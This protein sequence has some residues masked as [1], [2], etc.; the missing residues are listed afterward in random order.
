MKVVN[1]SEYRKVTTWIDTKRGHTVIRFVF[2]WGTQIEEKTEFNTALIVSDEN[3]KWELAHEVYI[4]VFYE[5]RATLPYPREG[6]EITKFDV[7]NYNF[8]K[9]H[10]R[11][12]FEWSQVNEPLDP[13]VFDYHNFGLP[14][15]TSVIGMRA[16]KVAANGEVHFP[17]IER[18]GKRTI[19]IPK[20]WIGKNALIAF[21]IGLLGATVALVW[22]YRRTS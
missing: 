18:L 2:E 6:V 5:A 8:R 11:Y 22:R 3:V 16:P 13:S 21:A 10:R 7:N 17:E 20:R 19:E 1:Q 14:A 15:G 9:V 12:D 4:P